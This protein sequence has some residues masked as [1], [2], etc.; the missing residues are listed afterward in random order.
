M[1]K[2]RKR[3]LSLSRVQTGEH[4]GLEFPVVVEQTCLTVFGMDNGFTK[5][6]LP[7]SVSTLAS[8]QSLLT[9]SISGIQS[10]AI[11]TRLGHRTTI[12]R[13]L[14][15]LDR[16]IICIPRFRNDHYLPNLFSLTHPLDEVKPVI[17]RH[18]GC[19]I[20]SIHE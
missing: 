10:L 12:V 1:P 3:Q 11:S 20:E 9:I 2:L 14:L 18:H 6:A 7:F 19:T 16:D 15:K 13:L 5:V 4:G 17:S 8:L